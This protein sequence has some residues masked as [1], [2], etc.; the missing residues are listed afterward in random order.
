MKDDKYP[1]TP[2]VRVLRA[3]GVAF[4]GHLYEY[5]EKGGTRVSSD[6]L[7]VPEHEVIKTIVFED[8]QKQPLIVLMHG[9]KEI[10]TQALARL[11]GKKRITPCAPEVAN[12]HTGYMVGGTSPFGTRKPLPVYVE[13]SVLQL[14]RLYVNGGKRGFLVSMTPS[15]LQRAVA[16]TSVNV[17][18]G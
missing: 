3:A 4:E 8:D 15:D 11:L 14:P 13:A 7:G 17:A 16:C 1:V 6:A 18:T 2:A 5:V 9:D 10:S 12:K